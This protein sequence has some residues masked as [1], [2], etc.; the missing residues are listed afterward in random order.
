MPDTTK[1][2]LGRPRF[3]PHSFNE[4]CHMIPTEWDQECRRNG[5]DMVETP[6]DEA[7]REI[8]ARSAL[9]AR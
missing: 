9:V 6:E 4:I 1:V 8:A 5:A 2:V 7:V 3:K